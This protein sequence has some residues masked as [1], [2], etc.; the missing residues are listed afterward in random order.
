MFLQVSM[1]GSSHGSR[2]FTPQLKSFYFFAL[3][4]LVSRL[5][6]AC[7]GEAL[8]LKIIPLF[9]ESSNKREAFIQNYISPL[10]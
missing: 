9:Y 8:S 6:M 1:V 7:G 4:W 3:N 10:N 2:I 5:D